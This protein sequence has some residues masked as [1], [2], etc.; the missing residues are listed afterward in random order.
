MGKDLKRN[1]KKLL[2]RLRINEKIVT[3]IK[4]LR[5]KY[6]EPTKGKKEW[7]TKKDREGEEKWKF[8]GII[9]RY[10]QVK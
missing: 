3:G 10:V 8:L 9:Y 2:A 4:M 7:E 6:R 1:E 5:D